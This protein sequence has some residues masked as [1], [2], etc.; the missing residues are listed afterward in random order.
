MCVQDFSFYATKTQLTSITYT[1]Q[2]VFPRC[3]VRFYAF[4]GLPFSKQLN[5]NKGN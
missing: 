5:A 3:R 1:T 4:T 2:K